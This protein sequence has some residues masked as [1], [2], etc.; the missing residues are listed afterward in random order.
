MQKYIYLIGALLFLPYWIYIFH[1]FRF[2]RKALLIFSLTYGIIGVA[3]GWLWFVNDW[4]RPETVLGYK[5]GIEDFILGFTNGGIASSLWIFLSGNKTVK[6]NDEKV[7]RFVMPL[8]VIFVL[9]IIFVNTL[10][11]NSSLGNSLAIIL[12]LSFIFHTR[13]DLVKIA[14]QGGIIMA[15]LSL[16]VYLLILYFF[17]DWVRNIWLNKQLSGLLFVG[18]PIEDLVWYFAVGAFVSVSYPYYKGIRLN[19]HL[20]I[21]NER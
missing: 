1:K 16:P 2:F 10:K 4:W 18:V 13:R 9:N 3:S 11:I 17:P 14:L 20:V 21:S 7:V 6:S 8:V 19:S 5:V 12:T 15:L